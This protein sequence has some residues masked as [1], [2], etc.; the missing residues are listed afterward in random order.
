[1][2]MT[3]SRTLLKTKIVTYL[4]ALT[5]EDGGAILIRHAFS[6]GQEPLTQLFKG[7][8]EDLLVVYRRGAG[9][10]AQHAASG[11]YAYT[12][13]VEVGLACIDKRKDTLGNMRVKGQ[14][15]LNSAIEEIEEVVRE[16]SHGASYVTSESIR[17]ENLSLGGRQLL[18]TAW[19][20]VPVRMYAV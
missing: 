14:K 3:D 12:R 19:L 2:E 1:L 5:D 16:Q 18:F 10:D 20:T 4:D 8:L 13:N 15:L 9:R 6:D 17:Y 11:I 7:N